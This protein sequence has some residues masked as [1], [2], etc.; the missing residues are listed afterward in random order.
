VT[1]SLGL[2]EG[3]RFAALVRADAFL[4]PLHPA[5]YIRHF[6]LDSQP[7][8]EPALFP[9]PDMVDGDQGQR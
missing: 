9:S 4:R 3:R 1:P 7:V 2:L 6:H 8:K 5:G